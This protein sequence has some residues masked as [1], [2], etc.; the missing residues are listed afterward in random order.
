MSLVT[1][2]N[3]GISFGERQVVRDVSFTLD[4][5]ETRWWARVGLASR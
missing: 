1:V 5:G 4:R 3:L 2:A